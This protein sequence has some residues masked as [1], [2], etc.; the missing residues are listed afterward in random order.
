MPCRSLST[1]ILI[2]LVYGTNSI[3]TATEK[4]KTENPLRMGHRRSGECVAVAEI[5]IRLW[6][7]FTDDVREGTRRFEDNK[8]EQEVVSHAF[9]NWG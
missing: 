4:S 8:E 9:S 7:V 6:F 5:A 3:I 2:C 1:M